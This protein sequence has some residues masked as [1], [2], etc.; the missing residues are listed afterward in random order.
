M[1]EQS[2]N[3]DSTESQNADGAGYGEAEGDG[4]DLVLASDSVGGPGR[5]AG[6]ML[7]MF[8]II[9]IGVIYFMRMHSGP[10]SAAAA[11]VESITAK[12]TINKFLTDGGANLDQMKTMLKNTEKVVE[13]FTAYPALTQIQV[14]ELQTNPFQ[15]KAPKVDDGS[16]GRA[17]AAEKLEKDLAAEKAAILK[18]VQG[19]QI[20]SL[21]VSSASRSA[22]ISNKMYTESQEVD[23]F[24]LEKITPTS[25]VVSRPSAIDKNKTYRFELKINK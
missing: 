24:V 17:A 8:L 7:V 16:G 21:L 20:Q 9:G 10:Q 2:D 14:E 18:S 3:L 4:A 6:L 19:M 5:T 11:S 13:Q 25:V 23:G 15:Y 1:N 12:E 22:M